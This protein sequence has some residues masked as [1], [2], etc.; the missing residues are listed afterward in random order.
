MR[1]Y[2][3]IMIAVLSLSV[4]ATVMAA[5]DDGLPAMDTP[6]PDTDS[7]T[8][9]ADIPE[10][11]GKPEE[12]P[13]KELPDTP[14]DTLVETSARETGSENQKEDAAPE[15]TARPAETSRET[16]APTL[17]SPSEEESRPAGKD[18]TEETTNRPDTEETTKS[19]KE[20]T[21]KETE[22]ETKKEDFRSSG[23]G[24]QD[25]DS[26]DPDGSDGEPWDEEDE[27]LLAAMEDEELTS[28]PGSGF[29][30]FLAVT[31]GLLTGILIAG[32][33]GVFYT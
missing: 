21:E 11:S 6:A 30:E 31:L 17:P 7:G 4:P 9:E 2:I 1:R 5:L 24:S 22:G 18:L 25:G 23:S 19:G 8:L 16:K 20:E 32:L 28:Q 27:I 33:R 10:D 12:P 15:E 26:K 14:A 3:L 13:E 29:P